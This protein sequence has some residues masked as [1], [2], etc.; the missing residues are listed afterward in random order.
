MTEST[1]A[2]VGSGIVGATIAY[3]LT[4]RGFDVEVFEKGPE[5]PYPHTAQFREQVFYRYDNPAY[6]LSADLKNHTLSGQYS[7]DLE[8]ERYMVVGGSATRWEA[9]TLRMIPSDFKTKTLYGYGQDWPITYD[10]LEPYYCEAE[11]LLGVSGTDADNPFA[12][13]RSRPYPLPPFE[14]SYGDLLL[15]GRL[16]QHDLVLHTTPQARTRLAY[17]DR[18]QCR[19]FGT[20]AFCPIGARY[21]PNHHLFRAVQTGLCT[22]RPN[23]SVRRI[24]LDQTGRARALVYQANDAAI[25]QEHGA[26]VI[27]VAAGGIESPRLLL[28]S[29]G[30]RYPDGLGN[31]SGQ[32]G[33]HLMFHHLWGSRFRYK[34]PLYPD[35]FGGW[36]G[37]IHQFLDPVQRGKHGGIKIEFSDRLGYFLNEAIKANWRTGSDVVESLKPRLHWRWA[38]FHAESVPGPQKYVTLSEQPDRFGDPFAHVQYEPVEF[39]FESH[40]YAQELFNRLMAASEADTG[41]LRRADEFL[42]GAHHLGTCRMGLEPADSVVDQFCR[43]H[44]VPN[45]FVVGGSSFVGTGAVNPTLTMVALAIRTAGYIVDQLL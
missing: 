29:T 44:D 36:T 38:T 6:Q 14:L 45:L 20:C 22:V 8:S 5:F 34:D 17:E 24:V 18:A 28:L 37:Q 2:V 16:R 11:A 1:V 25:E 3:L 9:I 32:V 12:P 27:I 39:D 31:N 42:S 33:Q 26:K 35:R 10:D 23:V 4:A 15:A 19:N 30:D 21:S 7:G 40:R 13:P 41:E 43:L